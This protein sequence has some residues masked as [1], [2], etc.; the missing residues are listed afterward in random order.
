[1]N[2]IPLLVK[3]NFIDFDVSERTLARAEVTPPN[4]LSLSY[5]SL[6]KVEVAGSKPA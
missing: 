4:T 6:G 2:E 3:N 5:K 1:M